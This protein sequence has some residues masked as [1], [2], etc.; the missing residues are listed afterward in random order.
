MKRIYLL[1]WILLLGGTIFAQEKKLTVEDAIMGYRKG[2]YPIGLQGVTPYKEDFFTCVEQYKTIILMDKTGRSSTPVLSLEDINKSLKNKGLE[3]LNY[4][5][6]WSYKWL[7]SGDLFFTAGNTLYVFDAKKKELKTSFPLPQGS[8]DFD[9]C[10]AN[11]QVAYTLKNNL[12]VM[13][14]TGKITPITKETDPGIVCGSSYVHRQEFG[15]NKGTFWSPN[16]KKLAFYRKDERK[17]ADYP[18]VTVDSRIASLKNIK[19]PMIGEKSEEVQLGVYDFA[20]ES[21]VFLNVT[22]FTQER[23]LTSVTWG[24][25][26]RY[27]YTGILNRKQNHLK[28]NKYA[29]DNGQFVQT[30]F[31]EKNERYVEPENPLY[32]VPGKDDKFLV[33]SERDG[34]SHLYLYSTKGQLL[35]QMTSGNWIVKSFKGFDKE[36]KNFYIT[37]TKESPTENHLY[38]VNYKTGKLQKISKEKGMHRFV[39]SHSGKYFYDTYSN[40]NTPQHSL[41]ADANGKIKT[42]FGEG[43]NPLEGYKVGS[44]QLGTLKTKDGKTDL[45]YRLITPPN[46]NKNKKYPV[47]VYVYGG[48]HAQLVTNSWLGGGG[49]WDLYMAQEGYILFTLDNRGS[50]NRGFEFESCIHRQCGQKEMSDQMQGVKFLKNLPYVDPERIGVHG[51]SYGGFMT[52]SLILNYPEI[53]KVAVA[54]GPVIDWKYYEVMYG[55][56]YMDTPAENPEGFKKTSL[57]HK[58]DQLKGRLLMIHGYQD[59]VVVP[60][61]SI[62]FIRSCIKAKT[63][64]DYFL[65]PESEHNM[66]GKNR[67]HLKTKVTRF[68]NDFLK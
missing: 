10:E 50:A 14:E 67:V 44:I 46:L 33:F 9:Y 59:P 16:G 60:Q 13:N 45:H 57:L 38:K 52:T 62:D 15:I 29:A 6:Y 43:K 17:V 63:D 20:T 34:Y 35:K 42:D 27:I 47:V 11:N 19:Y 30:L 36:K 56:R 37:A 26:S 22:D 41:I 24:P 5:P 8:Q 21:T 2:L 4:I 18:L 40:L 66:Q 23:Y 58:A 1:F 61:N 28:M 7:A 32:F 3:P 54:G 53:F 65:Y 25:S 64:L 55:E 49:L 31:E 48:P 12:F 39:L 51:W 68:F